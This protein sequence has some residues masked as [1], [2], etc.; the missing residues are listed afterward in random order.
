MYW[1]L[2]LSDWLL[3]GSWSLLVNSYEMLI[4]TRDDYDVNDDDVLVV[5]HHPSASEATKHITD[6]LIIIYWNFFL[7]FDSRLI[8]FFAL[9]SIISSFSLSLSL[10]GLRNSITVILL[11]II[12]ILKSN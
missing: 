12:I 1:I 11:M 3:D 4:N 2:S 5:I 8:L 6:W 9:F 10:L 7:F